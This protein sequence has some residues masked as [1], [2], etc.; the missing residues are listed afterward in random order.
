MYFASWIALG[1]AFFVVFHILALMLLPIKVQDV[2]TPIKVLNPNH[3]V[4]RGE[5]LVL[6]LHLK[7]YVDHGSTVYPA[8][9]CDDGTYITYPERKSNVPEGEGTY[10]ISNVY[11]IPMYIHPNT[12]CTT[13][14]TDDF[15]LNILRDKQYIYESEP[16]TVIE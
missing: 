1:V 9:L 8:I 14:A 5:F 12:I 7:K 4:R 13:R 15:K 11:L 10:I 3:Q 16:F 6:Q 2:E